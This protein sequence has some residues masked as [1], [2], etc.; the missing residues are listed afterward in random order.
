MK[1]APDRRLKL[2]ICLLIMGLAVCG[3][4]SLPPEMP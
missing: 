1:T 4:Q 3:A 2:L